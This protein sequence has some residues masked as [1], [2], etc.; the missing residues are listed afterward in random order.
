MNTVFRKKTIIAFLVI[1]LV[2]GLLFW[3]LA[4]GVFAAAAAA[5]KPPT[6]SVTNRG[7]GA[8]GVAATVSSVVSGAITIYAL[9]YAVF[10]ISGYLVTILAALLDKIFVY[11]IGWIPATMPAVVDGWTIMRDVVNALFILLVLWIAFTII[12]NQ[13]QWG[14]KKL[15]VRV[16]IIALTINF[17]MAL[18][19]GIFQVANTLAA[20]FAEKIGG[21]RL[22]AVIMANTKIQTV[23]KE[24]SATDL[25]TLKLQEEQISLSDAV[26]SKNPSGAQYLGAQDAKAIEASQVAGICAVG[27]FIPVV[28]PF[29]AACAVGATAYSLLSSFIAT[30]SVSG[31]AAASLNGLSGLVVGTLLLIITA[32]ALATACVVI[33]ARIVAMSFL[34]ILAPAAFLSFMIPGKFGQKYWN[35]W[36]ENLIKWAFYAPAFYFLLYIA[37]LMLQQMS[38]KLI[39]KT[40][41]DME[42]IFVLLVFLG[43][44][45][46]AVKLSKWM[47]ITV[48][49]GFVN[50]GSK[51]ALGAVSGGVGLATGAALGAAT[52]WG[53]AAAQK[54]ESSQAYE[55]AAPYVPFSGVVRKGLQKAAAA[56]R[57]AVAGTEKYLGQQTSAELQRRY[58]DASTTTTERAGILK[59]LAKRKDLEP[60]PGVDK[61]RWGDAQ[62]KQGMDHFARTGN[63]DS[64]MEIL[65]VRPDFAKT[66]YVPGTSTDAEAIIKVVK[67]M[68]DRSKIKKETLQQAPVAVRDEV[69]R[70]VWLHTNT[71][72]LSKIARENQILMKEMQEYINDPAYGTALSHAMDPL[73]AQQFRYYLAGKLKKSKKGGKVYGGAVYG[74][75]GGYL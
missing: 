50:W 27:T 63:I 42:R 32:F 60:Q 64:V 62:L 44:L 49:D 39:T 28:A 18:V 20:P 36:L 70:A 58:S 56:E 68:D 8:A 31:A 61:S 65:K 5:A 10:L 71:N 1:L 6:T 16:I 46:G 40:V 35:M 30:G 24:V 47:G 7:S 13:E 17:S 67:E 14:G 38:A 54:I 19:S 29:A 25:E 59:I 21:G 34:A 73:K 43:F 41:F 11:N 74:W 55:K 48:A 15:L 53:G 72:E 57:G 45:M 23:A 75:D 37:L 12:F 33:F 69:I 9:I 52:R 66:S 51:L 3:F 2:A 4:D 26:R 22:G